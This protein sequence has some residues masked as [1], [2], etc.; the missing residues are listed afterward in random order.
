[1]TERSREKKVSST[2]IEKVG[3]VTLDYTFYTGDDQ[4]SDGDAVEN[5]LLEI[6]KNRKDYDYA[7][8]EYREW[9][10]LY[11]LSRQRENIAAPMNIKKNDSL[12]EIGAGPGA[13]TG[14]F[15]RRA[16]HVDCIEL[17]KRRSMINAVRHQD[18]DNLCIYVGNFND[19]HL[20]KQY[21]VI[22]LIGVL[23]YACYY[24]KGDHPFRDFLKEVCAL[25]KPGGRLY[26]AIENKLG[27]KYFA[28]Y[29]EDHLGKPYAGIEG[30]RPE[31]H[32]RTF[33]RSE[34]KN[35]LK[36]TG[37]KNPYFYYP[38]P[39]YKL[40]TVIL[41]EESIENADIEFREYTNYDLPIITEFNQN[42]AFQSLKGTKERKIFANSFLVEAVKG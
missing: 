4:Y 11:H 35:L 22:T 27:M 16:G 28:G 17:S 18:M 41:S 39:D 37:F 24:T 19:V 34:L 42:K 36:S 32:V 38:F 13:V 2:R 7:M 12:L 21:D 31:D 6:V 25:L 40:P 8:D 14:A 20:K 9:P 33:T 3:K 26:V 10:V 5:Q 29:H 30:Y 23:E 15:A 1:M